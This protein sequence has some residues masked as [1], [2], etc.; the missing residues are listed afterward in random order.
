MTFPVEYGDSIGREKIP[1][2]VRM[3]KQKTNE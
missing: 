1:I 3:Q 2:Q